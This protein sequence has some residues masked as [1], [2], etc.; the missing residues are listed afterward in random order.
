[1]ATFSSICSSGDV[2]VGMIATLVSVL[3]S[4]WYTNQRIE[5]MLTRE[6]ESFLPRA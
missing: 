1:M 6:K 3:I 2:I 4:V 5:A